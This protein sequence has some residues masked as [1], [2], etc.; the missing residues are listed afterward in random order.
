MKLID[1]FLH[2][3]VPKC[4]VEE[5]GMGTS[6]KVVNLLNSPRDLGNFSTV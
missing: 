3:N 6:R 2:S 4:I 5:K 1:A